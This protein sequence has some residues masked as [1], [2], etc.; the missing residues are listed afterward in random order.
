MPVWLL[1]GAFRG[2]RQ[3]TLSVDEYGG[4]HQE[5]APIQA[6]QILMAVG[7]ALWAILLFVGLFI[8]KSACGAAF[9]HHDTST[10]SMAAI[11]A[12]VG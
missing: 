6:H 9:G 5:K 10:T 2:E 11:Q 1:M 7:A 12:V 4:A 3:T 8:I